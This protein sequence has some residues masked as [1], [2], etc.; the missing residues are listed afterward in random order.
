[1]NQINGKENN[2]EIVVLLSTVGIPLIFYIFK[3]F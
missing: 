3:I 1:M 2:G